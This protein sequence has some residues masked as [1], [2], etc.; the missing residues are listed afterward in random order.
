[1]N[2]FQDKVKNQIER[3]A[4]QNHEELSGFAPI[5]KCYCGAEST[6]YDL[7]PTGRNLYRCSVHATDKTSWGNDPHRYSFRLIPAKPL[8]SE[9]LSAPFAL[10]SDDAEVLNVHG[11][12]LAN[13]GDDYKDFWKQ[14]EI[15]TKHENVREVVT[16]N[17]DTGKFY[18]SLDIQSDFMDNCFEYGASEVV[19]TLREVFAWLG[20]AR[21]EFAPKIEEIRNQG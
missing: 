5:P 8:T 1:M 13:D 19:A 18:G 2:T 17:C 16:F 6:H 3:Y 9:D 14:D 12:L 7:L 20:Q 10:S 21:L 4:A 11:Y 15:L